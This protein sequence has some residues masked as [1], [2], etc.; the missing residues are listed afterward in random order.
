MSRYEEMEEEYEIL[1]MEDE[2][3]EVVP[4]FI[5]DAIELEDASYFLVIEANE[6]INY[7]EEVTSYIMKGLGT[8]GEELILEMLDEGDEYEEIAK[9]FDE[10]A[11]QD[12]DQ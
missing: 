2:D 5:I 12:L 9:L 4:F 11:E 7:D 10:A 6:D 3:G 8:D 1:E